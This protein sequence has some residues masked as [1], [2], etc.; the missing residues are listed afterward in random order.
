M[1]RYDGIAVSGTHGKSTTSGWL[2]YLLKQAG[3]DPNFIIGAKISQ[4]GSSSGV[5]DGKYFV[6]EACEYDRSFLN[7]KPKIAC[8]LNIEADHLDYYKDEDEIVE[9]FEQFA[10]GDKTRRR[11][12]CKRPGSKCGK[13]HQATTKLTGVVKPSGL[14]K[15][16]ISTP[17]I[18]S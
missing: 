11:A 6:A 18:F 3:I 1:N 15:I 12:D 13:D 14:M 17:K 10:Q 5:A 9:A 4:L 16:A 8:I 7:L 2:V